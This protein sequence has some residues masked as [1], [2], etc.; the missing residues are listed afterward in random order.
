MFKNTTIL[1]K[2]KNDLSG[3]NLKLLNLSGLN[4]S[5]IDFSRTDL[6]GCDLSDTDLYK[7][8]LTYAN[9]HHANLRRA[10]LRGSNLYYA[11]FKNAD[12]YDANLNNT[13]ICGTKFPE[14]D[15]FLDCPWGICHIRGD[16]I[17]IG[18]EYHSVDKWNNFNDDDIITMD[19]Y[20][21]VYTT[22]EWW[23]FNKPIIML[24]ANHL[25]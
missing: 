14:T 20:I 19:T 8:N 16:Y 1:N 2:Y 4:L 23:R 17:R 5:E 25:K 18:C 11:N 3:T 6:E 9:L 10:D 15:K 7:S 21:N 12:L 13:N 24:I 22:L